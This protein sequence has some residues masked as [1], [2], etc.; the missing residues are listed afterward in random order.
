M[1]IYSLVYKYD[2]ARVINSHAIDSKT[3]C[4]EVHLDNL[5]D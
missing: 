4:T 5:S 3:M 1:C 2:V